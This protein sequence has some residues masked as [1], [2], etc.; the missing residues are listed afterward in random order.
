MEG[1]EPLVHQR[2]N[3]VVLEVAYAPLVSV[4]NLLVGHEGTLLYG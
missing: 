1:R 2:L 4:M 3:L